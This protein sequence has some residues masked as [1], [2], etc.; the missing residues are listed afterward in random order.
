MIKIKIKKDDDGFMANRS[1]VKLQATD[2]PPELLL[3]RIPFQEQNQGE[4]TVV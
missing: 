4:F 1:F 3:I 2:V